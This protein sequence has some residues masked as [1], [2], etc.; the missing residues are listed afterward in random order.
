[1]P[2]DAPIYRFEDLRGK[3]VSV[4]YGSAAHGMLLKALV[5]RGLTPDFFTLINQAPPIGATS[6]QE[7]KIDAHADFCPWGELME[8]KGFGRKIFDGSQTSVAYLHG[9]VVRKDFLE[10]YPEI[11]VA[12]LKAVVEAN[13]WI[14][15]NPEE[16]TTKQE[17]WTSI[18]KEVLYLYFGRGGFL[19]LDATIKPRWVEVLKHDASVL[20]KMGIIKSADVEGFIDDRYVKQAYRE[21]GRDYARE[22][23][24]M[25]AGTSALEGKDASTGAPIK[26][27]RAAAEMWPKGE[28]VKPYATLASL[29]GALR[30]ADQAGRVV[31]AAYVF[32]YPTGLKLFAHRAFYV[33]DGVGKAATASLVAFA[34]KDE[35]EAFASKHGGRVL[36]LDEAKKLGATK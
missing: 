4:P 21:L 14:T 22:Q 9:P 6:I 13:E 10:K 35:A 28:A 19:T 23:R 2:A 36:S 31:N 5:D 1:V 15:R 25:V 18:P 27:A 8:F 7:K 33:A 34:W 24:V 29:M 20:Q 32:D 11:V 16:A 30:E 17:Q 12:Y 3:K 26:D